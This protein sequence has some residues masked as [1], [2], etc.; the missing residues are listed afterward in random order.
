MQFLLLLL[1]LLASL[2]TSAAIRRDCNN[3]VDLR[4]ALRAAVPGDDIV[5]H[6]GIFFGYF[7][8]TKDGTASQPITIRSADINNKAIV[9]G[10]S[11]FSF[12]SS[13]LHVSGNY[14]TLQDL[15]VTYGGKA[16]MFD[17]AIGG[18]ILNCKIHTTGKKDAHRKLKLGSV[19]TEPRCY[20]SFL[21]LFQLN[22]LLLTYGR[23]RSNSYSRW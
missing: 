23:R 14:W 15:E 9:R 20:I 22:F 3:N 12:D 2:T 16:I 5:L 6:P 8:A 17:N 13:P 19:R 21:I 18:K 10:F 4:N 7:Y 1:V 11:L